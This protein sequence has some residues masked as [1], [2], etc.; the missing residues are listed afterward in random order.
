[1]GKIE[2]VSRTCCIIVNTH[3]VREV[4]KIAARAIYSTT[5]EITK[6]V[7]F[8]IKA[9][10][11]FITPPKK[12]LLNVPFSSNCPADSSVNRAFFAIRFLNPT[13]ICPKVERKGEKGG[14]M[15]LFA[16]CP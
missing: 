4:E 15:N 6:K 8:W 11:A 5:S 1:M 14:T 9:A 16:H 7:T 10:P 12:I 13:F 3:M 2:S